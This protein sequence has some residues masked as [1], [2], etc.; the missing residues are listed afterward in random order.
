L[1]KKTDYAIVIHIEKTIY[2]LDNPRSKK[3][4]FFLKNGIKTLAMWL[5]IGIIFLVVVTTLVDNSDK[6]MNYSELISK[7][8]SAEVK[9]IELSADSEKAYVQLKNSSISKEVNIPSVDSF[10]NYVQEKLTEGDFTLTE[11]SESLFITILSLFSP[12]AIL[13]IFMV[14]WFLVMNNG[15]N[16]NKTMSFGKSRARL[17]P[18]EGNGTAAAGITCAG[19]VN[20]PH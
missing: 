17:M 2:D 11:K 6:K 13:I 3:G 19:T 18:T 4:G 16:G 8:D 20:A 15:Q 7:I 9:E 5:I 14:F 10:M 12:F 1:K